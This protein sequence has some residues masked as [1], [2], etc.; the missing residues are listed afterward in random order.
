MKIAHLLGGTLSKVRQC[1]TSYQIFHLQE[2]FTMRKKKHTHHCVLEMTNTAHMKHF[3]PSNLWI[4][5]TPSSMTSS[6]HLFPVVLEGQLGSR[7]CCGLFVLTLQTQWT[8]W[9]GCQPTAG[10][11]E[12]N[13]HIHLGTI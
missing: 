5:S 11:K 4:C 1:P 2:T 13:I 9:T 3:D 8:H 12:T 7:M 10:H 6:K